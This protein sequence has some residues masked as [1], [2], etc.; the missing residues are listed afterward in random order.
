MA[1]WLGYANL[2]A[3]TQRDKTG[4]FV[5]WIQG[6]TKTASG[7]KISNDSALRIA[8]FF[9]CMRNI[10]EDVGKLPLKI[11]KSIKPRGKELQF[12]HPVYRMIHDAPNPEMTAMTF[13]Q[14]LTSHCLG[15]GNGYAQIQRDIGGRPAALWPLR[16]DRIRVY[17]RSN[18]K[19]WYEVSTDDG[20]KVWLPANEMLHIPGL[21]Y[22][23]L[24]GYNVVQYAKESLGI[25][26]ASQRFAGA[27]F[28]NSA[29]PGGMLSHPGELS[30]KAKENLRHAFEKLHRGADNASRLMILEEGLK[31]DQVT[32]PL[33]D[34]QFIEGREFSIPEIC[35]WFRMQ[36]HKI[37]DLSRA[38][39]DNIEHQG[40]EYVT[41]TLTPW[42]T[43]WEQEIWRKLLTED[44]QRA[45]YFARHTAE[46]LLRGDIKTRYE[47]YRTGREWGWLNADDIRE[48]EDMNPLPEGLGEGYLIPLNM[49]EVGEEVLPLLPEPQEN[50]NSF[51]AII[52]DMAAR[53]ANAEIREV[54]KHADLDAEAFNVWVKKFY[55]K[56]AGYIK[57]TLAPLADGLPLDAI[58]EQLTT[59][60][61][62]AFANGNVEGNLVAWKENRKESI[63]IM[64]KEVTKNA[65]SK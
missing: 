15:W 49:R 12:E 65:L 56:H 46:G 59:E 4:W 58:A 41:D 60:G 43:R 24:Q 10:S 20:G 38:T 26:A 42:F 31:Y 19:I 7:E 33:K 63:V 45:G 40:I 64:L 14:T 32:M 54:E 27:F 2:K 13:R 52:S 25:A 22:D 16:P 50:A 9:A 35:R 57:K 29:I 6:G 8:A 5:E 1:G 47:A 53:L 61:V 18:N 37:H 30:K 28:G 34:A 11:Y 3:A 55:A 36:P 51:D 21:G 62:E 39:F 17:R 48:L 44:E 23:G